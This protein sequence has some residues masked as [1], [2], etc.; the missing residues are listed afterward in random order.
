MSYSNITVVTSQGTF[1]YQPGTPFVPISYNTLDLIPDIPHNAQLEVERIFSIDRNNDSN[2]IPNFL[3][4]TNVSVV[5]KQRVFIIPTDRITYNINTKQITDILLP[6]SGNDVYNFAYTPI[7]GPNV[8]QP[9]SILVPQ[10]RTGDNIIIRRKTVSNTPLVL[11]TAG[12]KLTTAQLNLNTTQL[13]FLAQELNNKITITSVSTEQILDNAITTS[14]ILN[15]AV[16]SDKLFDLNGPKRLLGS[17]N[18]SANVDGKYDVQELTLG[19]GFFWDANSTVLQVAPVQP[20]QR[21]DIN[22]V[23]PN[24]NWTINPNAVTYAK[25]QDISGSRLLG[26][27]STGSGDPQELSVANSLTISGTQ[28][29]VTTPLTDGNKTDITVGSNGTTFTLNNSV[30]DTVEL[31]NNAVTYGK[32]QLSN[33]SNRVLGSTTAG[34]TIQELQVQTDMVANAAITNDKLANSSISNNKMQVNSVATTNINDDAVIYTKIQKMAT[35]NRVLGTTSANSNPTE[36]QIQTDMVDNNAITFGKMQQIATN[37]LLGRAASGTGNVET[38]TITSAGRDLI[39]DNSVADMRQTLQLGTAALESSAS[40][41]LA[42]HTHG[43]INALGQIGTTA[44]LPLITGN[45]GTIQTGTFGS[46]AGTFAQGNDARFSDAR[47]PLAHTHPTTDIIGLGSAATQDTTAFAAASHTHVLSNITNAG[48]AAAKNVPSVGVNATATQV[49][50][51]DDTRLTDARTPVAH[52]HV[53]EDTTGLQTALEGKA[54]TS[55]THS[56]ADI[57][58]G[59][60]AVARGGTGTSSTPTAGQLLIGNNT[61]FTLATITAGT[62][63]AINNT[64]GGI[65]ISQV[66]EPQTPDLVLQNGTYGDISISGSTWTI[67]DNAITTVKIANDAV[68]FDKIQNINTNTVL[69]R[70]TA[71]TGNVEEITVTAAGRALLDDADA[72]AQRTTLGLGSAATQA[73]TAFAAASHT[74][75][76][77]NVTGLQ[78]ALDNK[79]DD[80]QASV[81][82]LSL[83][84]DA[85]ASAGRTTLGLGSA[86]T[87]NAPSAGNAGSTEVV[88]GND[89][90]LGDTRTPSALSVTT[91]TIANS[92]VTYAKMQNVTTANRVLGSTTAGGAVSETQVQTAMIADSA[93]T[94]AK[95]ASNAVETAKINDLAVTTAKLAAGAV[96]GEKI[97]NHTVTL[98]KLPTIVTPYR[99]LGGSATGTV[100]SEVQITADYL[101][102]GAVTTAKIADGNVTSGKLAAG[103]AAANLGNLGVTTALLNDNAV[104]TAKIT[105][106]NVTTDKLANNSVTYGKMQ[107]IA[108]GNRLLGSTTSGGAVSEVQVAEAMIETNAVT[109]DKINASAVTDAKIASNAVTTAKIL[110]RNVTFIKLPA[111]TTANRVLA[112][113]TSGVSFSELQVQTDMIADAA[114]TAAKIAPGA[115]TISAN[116]L[117]AGSITA[118]LLATDSVITAK[119]QDGAVTNAK[120]ANRAGNSVMGRASNTAGAV[121][122]ITAST[123]GHALRFDGTNVGFGTIPEAGIADGAITT[124]KI[125]DGQVTGAKIL[126]GS[127]TTA[128]FNSNLVIP[129]ANLPPESKTTTHFY[130]RFEN[131][132][133]PWINNIPANV[134]KITIYLDDIYGT[135]TNV[136]AVSLKVDMQ[137]GFGQSSVFSG[138]YNSSAAVSF[139]PPPQGSSPTQVFAGASNAFIVKTTNTHYTGNIGQCCIIKLYRVLPEIST[140][141][142]WLFESQYGGTG[143][144]YGSTITETGTASGRV[145]MGTNLLTRIGFSAS[146]TRWSS[147]AGIYAWCYVTY[148]Y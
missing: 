122:D 136:G 13:L 61:G 51:G 98:N 84:D 16:T 68:T 64:A 53:I 25:M 69:G 132:F 97:T 129:V 92:A 88:L 50:M 93:I 28:L 86:S 9:Q 144:Q 12:S 94:A 57:T 56:A 138:P 139:A 29:S 81:F 42:S 124:N 89:S 103:A 118:S 34:T 77:A 36:V 140:N 55:H 33:Q 11:W 148:E 41:A 145:D 26:R 91:G 147:N 79:L 106:L 52:T 141:N 38:I 18:V 44:N 142:V 8:G 113:T 137:L 59:T 39:D 135:I 120:I 47:N 20:G 83:L 30:V 126:D 24:T 48:T 43:N 73:S 17:G 121:A 134:R 21:T 90:R 80:S 110:D 63:I 108:T 99:V 54:A 60:L 100:V 45:N 66:G 27:G 62:N 71:G 7:S 32:M 111:S 3:N 6:S 105:N 65:T 15:G 85:D 4:D 5:D 23:E 125:G 49:V 102:N 116:D 87:R 22:V 76:I 40:F 14:K 119:I 127:I 70:A 75:S 117:A 143:Q 82:G 78:T 109:S 104:T 96:T 35:A 74:H 2:A 101:A 131:N 1:G 107:T 19:D 123:S 58:S 130:G 112:A 72:A 37:T 115:I 67:A 114:I 95:V 10:L 31:A 46:T 146:S 133:G 128:K